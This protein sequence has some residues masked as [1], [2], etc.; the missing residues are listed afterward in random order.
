MLP[1]KQAIFE[2]LKVEHRRLVRL[3]LLAAIVA[4]LRELLEFCGLAR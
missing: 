4:D 1:K 3:C 2:C